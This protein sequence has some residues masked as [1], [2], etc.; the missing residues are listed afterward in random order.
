MQLVEAF[1]KSII[2][3]VKSPGRGRGDFHI[4]GQGACQKFEKNSWEVPRSSLVSVVPILSNTLSSVIFFSAQII[5]KGSQKAST[6]NLLRVNALRDSKTALLTPNGYDRH[7]HPIYMGVVPPYGC[8]E[9][10]DAYL[11]VHHTDDLQHGHSIL[12]VCWHT[13]VI[14]G[15]TWHRPSNHLV[16]FCRGMYMECNLG[17][18][19]CQ[20]PL[21]VTFFTVF[22]FQT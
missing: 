5:L 22:F 1:S 9:Y 16:C 19:F 4:K 15:L 13:S 11:H 18:M 10:Q 20:I 2:T 7:P 14:P 17:Y 21:N 8:S 3:N 6:V 12:P